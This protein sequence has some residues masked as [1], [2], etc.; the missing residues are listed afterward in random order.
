MK[1]FL[2]LWVVF[3]LVVTV[4]PANYVKADTES[5]V[6]LA[7]SYVDAIVEAAP[8]VDEYVFS[9]ELAEQVDGLEN[10]LRNIKDA[11]SWQTLNDYVAEKTTVEI[12]P[13]ETSDPDESEVPPETQTYFTS[14]QEFSQAY[15]DKQREVLKTLAEP[16][17]Q[18]IEDMLSVPLTKENYEFA[19]DSYDEASKHIRDA[20]NRDDVNSLNQ[21]IELM[22]LMERADAAFARIEIPTRNSD[23]DD[24]DFFMED[25]GAAKT[26]YELYDSKFASLKPIYYECLQKSIK[27]T[28]FEN[29]DVYSKAKFHAEVENAYDDLGIYDTFNDTVKEKMRALQ[30]A[31]D[32]GDES[33]FHISVF[34]YY[35]GEDINSVLDQYRH[36]TELEEMVALISDTPANK[37]ELTAALRAYRYYNEEMTEEE[38]DLVPDSYVTKLDNAV[39]LNTNAEEV[40]TAIDEIGIATSEEEFE[41]YLERYDKA[42]RKYRS[43][44]NN[45]SGLSDIPSLIT[46]VA[47]LDDSTEVLEM[48]KS[49]RQIEE[50][51]DPDKCSKKLWMESVLSGYE[52]MSSEKQAGV[53]NIDVL[54][55]IY[56]DVSAADALRK[57]VDVIIGNHDLLDEEYVASIHEDYEKLSD[58][59]K[60]YFGNDYY[61][62]ILIIDQDLEA[63]NIDK[64]LYVVGLINKI[65]TVEINKK[66]I[67]DS[68]RKAYD[69]LAAEQKEYVSNYNILL[70]AEAALA[71]LDFSVAKASVSAL[72]SYSYSGYA[73]TPAMIVRL[74]GVLLTQDI[75][76]QL[77]YKSNI[78]AG[79]ASVT[80]TGIGNYTGTLTKN[81]TIR[82]AAI[83]GVTLSG[84][85]NKYKYTGE[86]IKPVVTAKLFD[87]TLKEG[88]DYVVS[89]KDN[90]N[91]GTATIT[92][93]G[94]GNFTGTAQAFF[95]IERDTVKNAKI[96]GVKKSYVKTGKAI[97]P[98]VKVKVS[99]KTL[100]KKRD[101]TVKYKKN[102]KRG[103]A[104]ITIKGKGNYSGS[105]KVKFKIV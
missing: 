23:A 22:T 57:R 54:R 69:G 18:A 31:V 51:E 6:E 101:Y 104:T 3:A 50:A 81:F 38:R 24:F 84:F 20:V 1:K 56:P 44:V 63:I 67:I 89:F 70:N 105:K 97:K 26:A 34:D 99:G 33:E 90:K 17:T 96:S 21:I 7:M 75:D 80:I 66:G 15:S 83:T 14:V 95:V 94:I 45:Y 27:N 82:A 30:E 93:T 11:S 13:D 55:D 59:A 68:A 58:R 79:T 29:Y 36:L 60:R 77:T 10:I 88:T 65:G 47:I 2:T 85:A 4:L 40:M 48:I 52:R 53:Y 46:N 98:D 74:N 37:T 73:L 35:R 49:I 64:A 5:D 39:L 12:D 9:E 42:Y 19:Y 62:K 100:K 16:I 25:Y 8:T 71:K 41:D 103:T 43:F 76:Y 86:A 87:K 91:R 72:G 78:N 61:N 32:A 28:L 102:K 92:V